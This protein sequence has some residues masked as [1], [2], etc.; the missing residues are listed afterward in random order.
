MA[1]FRSISKNDEAFRLPS[2]QFKTI[3]GQAFLVGDCKSRVIKPDEVIEVEPEDVPVM[4]RKF[5]NVS[6][7]PQVVYLRKNM[8]G[9]QPLMPTTIAAWK[10]IEVEHVQD[11]RT[12]LKLCEQKNGVPG[13]FVEVNELGEP[14]E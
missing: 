4:M 7:I 11:V 12:F 10:V 5:E 8:S 2:E 6:S 14:I 9:W 3:N 13:P 1:K